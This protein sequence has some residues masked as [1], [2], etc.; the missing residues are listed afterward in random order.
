M[1]SV[2]LEPMNRHRQ[3]LKDAPAPAPP[4]TNPATPF[5][6]LRLYECPRIKPY[7]LM[8]PQSYTR[9]PPLFTSSSLPH[10]SLGRS[11]LDRLC[12]ARSSQS[13]CSGFGSNSLHL[14]D[15]GSSGFGFLDPRIS[16]RRHVVSLRHCYAPT[17]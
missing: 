10:L 12:L 5:A 15:F 11:G 2:K 17:R 8:Y 1:L 9:V 6:A 7:E 3:K 13:G 4:P 14:L 16:G